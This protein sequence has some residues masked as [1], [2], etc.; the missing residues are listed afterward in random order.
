M[1][2]FFES[3]FWMWKTSGGMY[4]CQTKQSKI[5]HQKCCTK[6]QNKLLYY[7]CCNCCSWLICSIN[8]YILGRLL[9][10]QLATISLLLS[11]FDFFATE[12]IWK[13]I[14]CHFIISENPKKKTWFAEIWHISQNSEK[15]SLKIQHRINLTSKEGL[16]KWKYTDKYTKKINF[17]RVNIET[18]KKIIIIKFSSILK[19]HEIKKINKKFDNCPIAS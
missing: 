2:F 14:Q 11:R 18:S 4:L 17:N 1:S 3:S 7:G 16:L 19:F 9:W 13:L 5:F 10:I 15:F 6:W 12:W 8:R